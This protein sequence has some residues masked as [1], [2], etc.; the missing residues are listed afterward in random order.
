MEA[1]RIANVVLAIAVVSCSNSGD[2]GA[3]AQ[4]RGGVDPRAPNGVGQMRA[5]P[6]QTRAPERKAT[7]PSM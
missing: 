3:S 7:L 2:R 4:E 5:F 1:M 6:E